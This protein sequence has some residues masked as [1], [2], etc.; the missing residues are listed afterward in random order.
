MVSGQF[1]KSFAG[2]GGNGGEA[3]GAV[4]I[5][6]YRRCQKRSFLLLLHDHRKFSTLR[7]PGTP[8]ETT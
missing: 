6:R 8:A 1:E 5:G 4:E 2:A 3:P 7:V